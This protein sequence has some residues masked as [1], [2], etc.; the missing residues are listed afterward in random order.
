MF[1]LAESSVVVTILHAYSVTYKS[2][3]SRKVGKLNYIYIYIYKGIYLVREKPYVLQWVTNHLGIDLAKHL[4]FSLT[5][6]ISF[7]YI[8]ICIC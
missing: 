7:I 2:S 6:Q 3:L 8:P 5:K 4:I 1:A